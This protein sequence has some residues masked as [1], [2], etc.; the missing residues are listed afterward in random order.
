M[1]DIVRLY[2][3]TTTSTIPT[4]ITTSEKNKMLNFTIPKHE[5]N[6]TIKIGKLTLVF[7]STVLRHQTPSNSKAIGPTSNSTLNGLTRRSLTIVNHLNNNISTFSDKNLTGLNQPDSENSVIPLQH[8][9]TLK[10]NA[11][12]LNNYSGLSTIATESTN[13]L[14]NLKVNSEFL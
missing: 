11:F 14:E 9:Q 7:S 6:K 4:I 3:T 2:L 1:D 5:D 12:S 13:L 8:N 10:K